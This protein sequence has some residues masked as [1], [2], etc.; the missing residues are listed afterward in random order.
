MD[1]ALFFPLERTSLAS[2]DFRGEDLDAGA[3]VLVGRQGLRGKKRISNLSGISTFGRMAHIGFVPDIRRQDAMTGDE[4][5][6][7]RWP[8]LGTRT[9]R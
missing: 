2:L 7:F 9:S 1:L 8:G 6:R 4:F 3:L 5:Q